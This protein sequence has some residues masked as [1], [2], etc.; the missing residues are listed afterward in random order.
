MSDRIWCWFLIEVLFFFCLV[1]FESY[2]D[3]LVRDNLITYSRPRRQVVSRIASENRPT[4][5][6]V[7]DWP[8]LIVRS[9]T[10]TIVPPPITQ[11]F[12][13]ADIFFNLT[14]RRLP[15]RNSFRRID[16]NRQ[17][18]K[19]SPKEL[20]INFVLFWLE[21]LILS[22]AIFEFRRNYSIHFFVFLTYPSASMIRVG[23]VYGRESAV[24]VG[25]IH[26]A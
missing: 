9:V 26:A 4:T 13:V 15:S 3:G 12:V 21:I 25:T 20:D 10:R 6:G 1:H 7:T 22:D 19:P 8:R 2:K 17:S 5:N 18:R 23:F 11:E 16:E 14:E 24:F